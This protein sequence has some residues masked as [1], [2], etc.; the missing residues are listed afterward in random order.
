M[1]DLGIDVVTATDIDADR[2][3]VHKFLHPQTDVVC[4]DITTK[5]TK[6]KILDSVGDHVDIIIST[7][8]CQGMSSVGKNKKD[9][10]L[11]DSSDE[12]NFLMLETFEFIDKLSPTYVLF[13]N[14]PRLLKLK[15]AYNGELLTIEEILKKKYGKKYDFKIDVLNCCN[16]GVAQNRERTFIRMFLK[17]HIWN[18]PIAEQRVLTLR[19][20]IG[21]LPSIESGES[22][23]IKNHWARIHPANQIECMQHTP[24]GCTAFDNAVYY[25]KK[26]NGDRIKGYHNTYKRVEWDKP[27]PTVTMRNEV[28]SSQDKVHPGRPLP[29]GLWSDARVFSLRELLLIMSMPPDLDFPTGISDTKIRQFIGEG[30]PSLMMKKM[31][32][33]INVR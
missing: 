6:K 13:E 11:N 2:C 16:Y 5:E 3:E 19:D 22:S 25:P 8:P 18:D 14:V 12:R 33:G 24:T 29:N 10:S 23:S 1:R 17:G 15:I 4:G 21:D 7:P 9:S 20:I 30:V 26:V 32:E 28:I 31:M 27:S